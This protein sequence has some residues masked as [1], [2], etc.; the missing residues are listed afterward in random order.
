MSTPRWSAQE[1]DAAFTQ[2][3]AT[4]EKATTSGNWSPFADL[5]TEDASY[6]EHAYG[7][8]AGREEIR[9]WVVKTMT[10]FPGNHMT[11]FPATWDVVDVERGRVICEIQNPMRDPGD[12]SGHQSPNI[13]ILT[14]AGD[15]LWSCEEDVY[16][17]MEFSAMAMG[18]C[19]R[20][21]E[22]GTISDEAARWAAKMRT[23]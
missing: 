8:F 9:S 23:R 15:N 1:L 22:L 19:A 18:W 20:A 3:Q 10:S 16:N 2:F 12:G 7:N 17:P 4:V 11:H 14:Y 13:T 5:F 6:I 21:T